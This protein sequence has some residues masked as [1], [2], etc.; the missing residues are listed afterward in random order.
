MSL[1]LLAA[2]QSGEQLG[3]GLLSRLQV[4][5]FG[6]GGPLLADMGLECIAPP[7]HIMGLMEVVPALPKMALLFHRLKTAILKRNPDV[8][9]TIDSPALFLPLHRAL[10]RHGFQGKLIHWV[11]PSV[12]AW[13]AS[14]IQTMAKTLDLL[15]CLF[16]FEAAYYQSSGLPTLTIDHP[17][18]YQILTKEL[19]DE[20]R[21]PILALF[22]G[23]RASTLRVHVPIL[24]E[25]AR[26]FPHLEPVVCLARESLS[27]LIPYGIRRVPSTERYS[28]LRR[29]QGAIATMG[30]ICLECA[31]Q[32]TPTVALYQPHP[33]SYWIANY[34]FK[35]TLP[36]LTLPNLILQKELVQEHVD[37]KLQVKDLADSLRCLWSQPRLVQQL[38]TDLRHTFSLKTSPFDVVAERVTQLLNM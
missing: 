19:G 29:A 28:L 4:P 26:Q 15:I 30:T 35:I 7:P 33:I 16:P 23:S 20:P 22:P 9:I 14:R 2:E 37:Y 32:G 3:V 31:L 36:H 21:E 6:M 12:W 10:R 5:A 24:L 38:V 8:V 27:P 17:L 11:S 18:A 25:T 34:F 13:R 1:S